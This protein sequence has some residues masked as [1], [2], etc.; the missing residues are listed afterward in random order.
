MESSEF[1]PSVQQLLRGLEQKHDDQVGLTTLTG[2]AV[3]RSDNNVHLA[4]RGGIA[5]IPITNIEDVVFL[6]KSQPDAVRIAVRDPAAIQSLLRVRSGG[7]P[8]GG[9][10]DDGETA[11]ARI[12]EK[13]YT[14]RTYLVYQGVATCTYTDTDTISTGDGNPDQCDDSEPDNCPADDEAG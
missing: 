3:S 13:V 7:A 5:A 12:G 6:S 8:G 9:T 14:D 10:S 4:V 2:R 1:P 11:D